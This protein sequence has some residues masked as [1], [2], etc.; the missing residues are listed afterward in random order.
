MEAFFTMLS[1]VLI[2]IALAVPG[3]ILAKTGL[4]TDKES[5]PL[6]RILIYVGVPFMVAS[7]LIDITFDS[8]ALQIVL[9]STVV[10]ILYTIVCYFFSKPAT[11]HIKD[12]KTQGVARFEIFAGNNGFLGIPLAAAVFKDMPLVVTSV[13]IVNLINNVS[14]Y[15]IGIYSISGDK[16]NISLKK[17][18]TNP[19]LIGFAV[20]LILNFTK[21]SSILPQVSDYLS[22]SQAIVTPISMIIIGI[23]LGSIK[24]S[25]IFKNKNM[26]VVSI[27]KLIVVPFIITAILLVA[28][29]WLNVSNELILGMF[30]AFAVPSASLATTFADN[31]GGDSKSAAIFTIGTT[32]LSVLTIP[33]LYYLLML[34]I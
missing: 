24:L 21:V 34:I 29:I 5:T 9:L 1:N 3:Y 18:V 25:S 8:H 16:K 15:T 23:K 26:Y 28:K 17:L 20:G 10:G 12:L 11:S 4:V 30:V 22:R 33:A 14:M 6:S 19:C 13:I 27:Y 32:I 31:F 2:F 7:N